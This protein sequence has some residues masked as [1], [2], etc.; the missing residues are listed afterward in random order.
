MKGGVYMPRE[1]ENMR[2]Q[3]ALIRERFPN[4]EVFSIAEAIEVCGKSRDFVKKHIMYDCKTIC[5]ATL[6]NRLCKL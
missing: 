2:T 4:Q 3:I 5:T 6:A 1:P